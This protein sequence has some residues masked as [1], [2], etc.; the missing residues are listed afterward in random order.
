MTFEEFQATGRDVADLGAVFTYNAELNGLPGRVYEAGLYIERSSNGSWHLDI[1]RSSWDDH[2][3]EHLEMIL[4]EYGAEVG[5]LG[6]S[7]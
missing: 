5:A 4:Y 7:R 2:N 3:L 6:D 1:E